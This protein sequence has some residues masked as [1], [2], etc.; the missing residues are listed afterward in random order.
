MAHCPILPSSVS[1]CSLVFVLENLE[2]RKE[3]K[4]PPIFLKNIKTFSK[5]RLFL[6]T[7]STILNGDGLDSKATGQEPHWG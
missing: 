4:S 2:L 6:E 3:R 5:M 7:I 1:D